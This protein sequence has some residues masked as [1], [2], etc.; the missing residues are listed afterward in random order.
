MK[1]V[2]LFMIV[3]LFF[4]SI[5]SC[6]I[7]TGYKTSKKLKNTVTKLD[8]DYA[9]DGLCFYNHGNETS[10]DLFQKRGSDEFEGFKF[11]LQKQYQPK[12]NNINIEIK[13]PIY[14]LKNDTF[15]LFISEIRK[16]SFPLYHSMEYDS[17]K[18]IIM[19]I[20]EQKLLELIKGYDF[21]LVFLEPVKARLLEYIEFD[22]RITDEEGKI[23]DYHLHYDAK[24]RPVFKIGSTLWEYWS[25]I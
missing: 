5:T 12:E 2:L 9:I 1:K 6:Y 4:L 16:S 7:E 14:K 19:E 11:S 18:R 23:H 3:N 8:D 21:H 15:P 20:K 22:L 13:N 17:E 10:I 25:G 24:I